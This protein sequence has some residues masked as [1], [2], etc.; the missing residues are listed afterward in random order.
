MKVEEF[1]DIS[2]LPEKM[3]TALFK[4]LQGSA[5]VMW[6]NIQVHSSL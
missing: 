4:L 2:G 6:Q 3:C 1:I 5:E